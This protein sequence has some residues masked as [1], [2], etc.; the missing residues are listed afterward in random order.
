MCRGKA[1]KTTANKGVL[2]IGEKEKEKGRR[3]KKKR[4][5]KKVEVGLI[6][7]DFY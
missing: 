6:R 5:M 2:I 3:R 7:S 4:R 1:Q